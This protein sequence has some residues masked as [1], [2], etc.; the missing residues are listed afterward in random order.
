MSRRDERNLDGAGELEPVE[1]PDVTQLPGRLAHS[2]GAPF[3]KGRK[4]KV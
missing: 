4:G 1:L 2:Q 3:V